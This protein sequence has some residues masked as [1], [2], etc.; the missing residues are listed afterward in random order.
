MIRIDHDLP[1]GA[2][3]G[4]SE[5]E[6][7]RRIA[8]AEGIWLH[9][10]PDNFELD[11]EVVTGWRSADGQC[12]AVPTDPN[13]GNGRLAYGSGGK[14]GMTCRTGLHCG[15]VLKAVSQRTDV[16]SVAALVHLHPEEQARTIFTIN[17]GSGSGRSNPYLFVSDDGNSFTI[18]D[19]SEALILSVPALP[20]TNEAQLVAITLD[21]DRLSFRQGGG[22]VYS[23]TGTPPDLPGPVSLFIG[24]RSQ[25][26]GLQKTLGQS[27]IAD[28]FFW[29]GL[30]LLTPQ[31]PAETEMD[32]A[33]RRYVLWRG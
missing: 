30:R 3:I 5:A 20:R 27:V 31:H 12:R 7:A 33:L 9:G 4:G 24:A 18:K 15:M 32:M 8:T 2:L 19:T 23:V 21:G 17:S 10:V 11:G 26:P 13:D 29:P 22:E 16:F 6:L 28:V 25:R 14:A 1:D